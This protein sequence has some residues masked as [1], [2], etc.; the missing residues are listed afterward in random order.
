[1]N[2]SGRM[3]LIIRNETDVKTD[4]RVGVH[5]FLISPRLITV[6]N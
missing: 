3:K 4:V 6:Q 1:M 2:L 5:Y